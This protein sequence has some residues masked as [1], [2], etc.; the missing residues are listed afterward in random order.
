LESKIYL[1]EG[2]KGEK[3]SATSVLRIIQKAA[4]AAG[5]KRSISSHVLRQSFVTHLHEARAD[6]SPGVYQYQL[7]TEDDSQFGKIVLE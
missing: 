3:C 4:K 2:A 5:I 6:L 7:I 1:F